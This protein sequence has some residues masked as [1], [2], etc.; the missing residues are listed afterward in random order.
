MCGLN[1]CGLNSKLNGGFLENYIKKFDIFCVSES[2]VEEGTEIKDFT[3]YNLENRTTTYPLPGIHGLHVYISNHIAKTCTQVSDNDFYCNLVI[4][5][6]VA[7]SFILGALYIPYEGSKYHN[8]TIYDDL[9]L[10]ICNIKSKYD[11]PILLMGDFNSRTSNANDIMMI[12]SQDNILDASIF[13]YPDII[14]TL[15]SLGMPVTRVNKDTKINN[16]GRRLIEM[17]KLQELCFLN[18]RVGLDRNIGNLTCGDAS[19]ID[20]MLCT[21]DLLHKISHCEVDGFCF[22][23]S[24]K[25]NPIQLSI[26]MEESITQE[27]KSSKGIETPAKE[28]ITKCKWDDSKKEEFQMCFNDSKINDIFDIVSTVNATNATQE[29]MDNIAKN[30]KEIFMEP[31]KATRMYT[32]YNASTNNRR[33]RDNKPWFNNDCEASKKDYK[34]FKKS[35]SKNQNDTEKADLKL[36]ANKHKKLVR[37]E[38]RKFEK[39]LNAK[40][41]VLKSTDPGKYWNLINPRKKKNKIGDLS[42]DTVRTHFS[43]MNKDI[44]NS[45]E[46]QFEFENQNLVTNDII[47]GPFT[48]EEIKKHIDSLKKNKSPGADYI[49]NEFIK[50]CPEKLIYVIVALFN[51]VL[52]SG[53]IPSEWSIGIIKVLYKNKGNIN[54]VNNYRG[55][56]LLSCLGKLFTS[57][58]NARLYSYL[59]NAKILGNEQAGFRPKH[60][61]LDHIFALHVLS[62]F[63]VND[64]KQLFCAFVDYSKAFDFVDR[65]YLWQKLLNSNIN[66]KVL[67][68]VRNMYI[69]AKSHVS[70]KNVLSD[71]FPCQVGVRQGENLSPLLFAIYLNDFKTFLSEKYNGLSKVSESIANELNIYLR[72]FCLLYADDTIVLA[73]NAAQLQ[74]ALD[75][76]NNYCNKWALKV[77]LDKTKVVI[78]S[79]G[80]IRKYKSFTFGSHSVDVVDDYVY[81]GTTFNYNGNFNKAKAKQVLQAKKATFSILTKIRQSNLSADVFT[82][83]FER[84]CIPVLLYG[85]EIWGYENS[86]Q[87]QVMC[88]NT[89]RKFLKLHKSTPMCMLNGELGIKEIAEYIENRMLNFWC[90][91]ATGEES[92][93]STILYKWIKALH[94]KN[95]FKSVWLDKIKTILD[96]I[97]MSSSFNNI[98]TVSKAWFKNTIKQKLNDI[99]YQNWSVSVFSNSTCLNYRVM[100]VH[101][102]LQNYLLKLP[103]QYRY[104]ICKFKC[105]N[106]KMPIVNGRYSNIAVDARKCTLCNLKPKEIGDEFHYLFKCPFFKDER[107]RY[108]KRYF[109]NHPNMYKM[110]KLFNNVNHREMLNLGK[111]I[112][113]II[114]HF[115]KG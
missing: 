94:D 20:Y 24:D 16:N 97:G 87:L 78:F 28:C 8:N 73:E 83:L 110:T 92:K 90:N 80:K 91:I 14:N 49:L 103:S 13:K 54:D 66:G 7:K 11:M 30:L 79:K 56:T 93:I 42:L 62:N 113:I 19:T 88:N 71:S 40:I 60:S 67:N 59:T 29:S 36:M 17:C 68:V 38:K 34:E 41:R 47:N 45:S 50:F 112:Y 3:T 102:Q 26:K 114:C 6:K 55:I 44:S 74:K 99:Y 51:V 43:D 108:I 86:N 115:R 31:A 52:E 53:V 18:G 4:W 65:T 27:D 107:I 22:M 2:K 64:K 33:R 58:I 23:M 95:I 63:Y 77:N 85:S 12:E 39:E 82:E 46:N 10:D 72:I 57:V 21:P 37:K 32:Q 5:I 81:L 1:V 48:F 101:K 89:L 84:L 69:N 35:L 75:G 96:K 109:Y 111:F 25:H 106:H 98:T 76:L 104:A 105:A 15:I 70:L 9:S 61:T 100:T